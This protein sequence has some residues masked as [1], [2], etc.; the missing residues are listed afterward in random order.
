MKEIESENV[1]LKTKIKSCLKLVAKTDT[2]KVMI[3][4]KFNIK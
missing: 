3:E 2:Q 4:E 1:T